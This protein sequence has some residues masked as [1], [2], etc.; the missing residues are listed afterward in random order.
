VWFLTWRQL[1]RGSALHQAVWA[2]PSGST[3]VDPATL[4]RSWAK[5]PRTTSR[6]GNADPA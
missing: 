6:P 4:P 1:M 5:P 2:G 3:F